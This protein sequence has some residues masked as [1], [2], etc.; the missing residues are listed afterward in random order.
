RCHTVRVTT[1]H[2]KC[3]RPEAAPPTARGGTDTRPESYATMRGQGKGR[4]G[5]RRRPSAYNSATSQRECSKTAGQHTVLASASPRQVRYH[6]ATP[7]RFQS[8]GR[9][10]P[11]PGRN[12]NR[13]D[14]D[15][16]V[17]GSLRR[18]GGGVLRPPG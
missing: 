5:N 7:H 12:G 18:A 11:G 10:G 3:N 14:G 8:T 15:E 16:E 4:S 17:R 1:L 9:P 13:S 2:L 6:C